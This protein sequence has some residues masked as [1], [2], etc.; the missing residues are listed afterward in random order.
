MWKKTKVTEIPVFRLAWD[1]A[2]SSGEQRDQTA[3]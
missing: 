2:Y 1:M 3:E